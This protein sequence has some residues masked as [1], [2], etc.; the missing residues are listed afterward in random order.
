MENNDKSIDTIED[1]IRI[2]KKMRTNAKVLIVLGIIGIV[3]VGTGLVWY[4]VS[5]SINHTSIR[6]S[7]MLYY[8]LSII[9]STAVL[10]AGKYMYKTS[11]VID[12]GLKNKINEKCENID[13]KEK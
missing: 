12:A 8:M 6:F 10:S 5:H 1:I 13:D 3:C 11:S 9:I 4:V 2:K 7:M